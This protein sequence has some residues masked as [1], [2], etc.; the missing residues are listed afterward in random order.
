MISQ[1]NPW[2][3]QTELLN[4]KEALSDNWIT[5]GPKCAEAVE[6]LKAILGARHVTFAPNGTLGLFL[7]LIALDLPPGSKVLVPD[8][9]FFGSCSAIVMAGLKPISVDVDP[10]TYQMDINDLHNKYSDEVSAIMPVHIYG[11]GANICEIVEFAERRDLKVIEDAAQVLGVHY[12]RES[13]CEI[14]PDLCC[15]VNRKHLGTFGDIGVFSLYADKTVTAGEGGVVC[16]NDDELFEKI[17]LLRNQGRPNSGT[18]IHPAVGMNFRITDLQ[19]AILSAQLDKLENIK[20]QRIECFEM[21]LQ[22]LS[23]DVVVMGRV[24]ESEFIPFRMPIQVEDPEILIRMLEDKK[25]QGRRFFYPMS[26]QPAL[27]KY[28]LEGCPTSHNLYKTGVCLPVHRNIS[29]EN[30]KQICHI[31]NIY[32]EH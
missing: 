13:S 9:T 8:F 7:G 26:A 4:I 11:Q 6:K 30:I 31:V 18:F 14:S 25:I 28:H 27:L 16:T 24:V 3:D 32:L 10:V 19:G 29:E 5:E 21:Y 17:K 23:S 2:L 1:V 22:Y 12:S 15:S 20:K